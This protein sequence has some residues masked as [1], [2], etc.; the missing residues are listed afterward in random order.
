MNPPIKALSVR[1]PFGPMLIYP[2]EGQRKCIETRSFPT[3]TRGLIAIHVSKGYTRA[4]QD[5]TQFVLAPTTTWLAS[6]LDM[7]PYLGCVIGIVRLIDCIP[8]EE[9]FTRL[10]PLEYRFGNYAPG[11]FG[12]VT[13]L[14]EAFAKPIPA[15]GA[16]G[17]WN[18]LR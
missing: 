14:V 17:F 16:L 13:E 8:V 7:T 2:P 15:K 5:Y 9:L 12:W 4:E 18:W 3:F 6:H 10:T 11:R 1:A